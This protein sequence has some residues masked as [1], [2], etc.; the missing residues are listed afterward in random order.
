MKI[1]ITVSEKWDTAELDVS[2]DAACSDVKA[3]ALAQIVGENAS[4]DDYVVK[5]RGA[6]VFNEG[7]TL[8]ALGVPDGGALIVLPSRR[9]P[10]R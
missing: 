10:V 2:G 8:E 5:F 1:R 4:V 6:T 7:A 3:K 9:Q